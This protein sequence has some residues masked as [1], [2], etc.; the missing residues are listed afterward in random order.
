MRFLP[1]QWII[2][3]IQIVGRFWNAAGK[4]SQKMKAIGTGLVRPYGKTMLIGTQGVSEKTGTVGF[5]LVSVACLASSSCDAPQSGRPAENRSAEIV[6]NNAGAPAQSDEIGNVIDSDR[7]AEPVEG[8]RDMPEPATKPSAPEKP[9]PP[10]REYKPAPSQPP[11]EV[12]PPHRDP[13]DEVP[14]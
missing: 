9:S 13:G 2:E 12:D 10:R 11:A 7:V 4:L 8:E 3:E 14:Q 1:R 5:A 6:L